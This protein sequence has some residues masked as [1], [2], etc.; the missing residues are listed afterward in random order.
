MADN[1]GEGKLTAKQG[2]IEVEISV[3]ECAKMTDEELR[4]WLRK[5]LHLAPENKA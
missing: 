3:E 1:H 4:E 5:E 2:G